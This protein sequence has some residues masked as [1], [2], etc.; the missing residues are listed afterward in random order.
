MKAIL[1]D[2]DYSFDA[3]ARK[4]YLHVSGIGLAQIGLITNLSTGTIVYQFNSPTLGGTLVDG[5]LTLT[6]NTTSMSS[7]DKL[8]I[9]VD[10]PNGNGNK[11]LEHIAERL[12][13]LIDVSNRILERLMEI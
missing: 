6:F 1:R 4:V 9:I 7:H 5:V 2:Q 8:Q 11:Q 12:E 3:T 10:T 13:A